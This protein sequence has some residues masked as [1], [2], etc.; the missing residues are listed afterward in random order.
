MTLLAW[1]VSWDLRERDL[2]FVGLFGALGEAGAGHAFAEAAFLQE[3]LFEPPELLVEQVVGLVD[4]ANKNVGHYFG[5][6]GFDIGL[7]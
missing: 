2:R 1:W 4:Q 5:R 6:A 3:I 7:I